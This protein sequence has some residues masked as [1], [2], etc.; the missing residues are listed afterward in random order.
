MPQPSTEVFIGRHSKK[1][2]D[3]DPKSDTY[4]GM[5]K[6]GVDLAQKRARELAIL[7]E[8][9]KQG[10]IIFL[11]GTS[12]AP[13]TKSTTHAYIN[14]LS[15]IFKNKADQYLII[16]SPV[17][18]PSQAVNLIN[19]NVSRKIIIGYPLFLKEFS[20]ITSGWVN[21][22]Q[23]QSAYLKA[24]QEKFGMDEINLVREWIS[25][26]GKTDGFQGPNPTEVAK[27]YL[28]GIRRLQQFAQK[29]FAGRKVIIGIIG[30]SWDLD[31]SVTYLAKGKVDLPSFDEV[32]QGEIIKE[33]EISKIEF[34]Q[35]ETTVIYRG[36]EFK[37]PLSII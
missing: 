16:N 29:H 4:E 36:R 8:E 10:V 2:Q 13:R 32:T 11:A 19:Q 35:D 20:M 30:H 23:E 24:M 1:P 15:E 17:E 37:S 33:T 7:I 25:T 21:K 5:S 34:G 31:V 3:T 14:E 9:A 6:S 22:E 28:K 26:E 18:S 27:N 12:E